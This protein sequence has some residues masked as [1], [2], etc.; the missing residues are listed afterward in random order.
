MPPNPTSL[1]YARFGPFEF[2]RI[3]ATDFDPMPSP[4]RLRLAVLLIYTGLLLSLT[5]LF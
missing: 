1:R 3:D 4:A 5:G 2:D